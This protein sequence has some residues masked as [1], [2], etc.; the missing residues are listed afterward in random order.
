MAAETVKLD[1][2]LKGVKIQDL[3]E[4]MLCSLSI[5]IQY[6][7]MYIECRPTDGI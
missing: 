3:L 6:M 1:R 7:Y 2:V 4:H 5:D